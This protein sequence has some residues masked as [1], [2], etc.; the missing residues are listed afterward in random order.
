MVVQS[1]YN[2]QFER[3][4]RVMMVEAGVTVGCF[5]CFGTRLLEREIEREREREREIERSRDREIENA[6]ARARGITGCSPKDLF[7]R[8]APGGVSKALGKASGRRLGSFL[9]GFGASQAALGG[10]WGLLEPSWSPLPSPD[11]P[12]GTSHSSTFTPYC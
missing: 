8:C 1:I 5:G 6:R 4:D 7:C 9:V 10:S 2:S 12:A 3:S 11:G